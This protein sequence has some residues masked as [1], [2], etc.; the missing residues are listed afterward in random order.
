MSTPRPNKAVCEREERLATVQLKAYWATFPLTTSLADPEGCEANE[1]ST[2]QSHSH[3]PRKRG[4][5]ERKQLLETL[6]STIEDKGQA[7]AK[8]RKTHEPAELPGNS[9]TGKDQKD[10]NR[11]TKVEAGKNDLQKCEFNKGCMQPSTNRGN[12]VVAKVQDACG[13]TSIKREAQFIVNLIQAGKAKMIR[14]VS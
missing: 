3:D 13:S 6:R 10:F 9:E 4:S 2:G 1:S 11:G 8:K 14:T 12:N 5:N 7:Q